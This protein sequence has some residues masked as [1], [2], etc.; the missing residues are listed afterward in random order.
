VAAASHPLDLEQLLV[1]KA[2]SAALEEL[3]SRPRTLDSEELL[4]AFDDDVIDNLDGPSRRRLSEELAG[5][6]AVVAL[7]IMVEMRL[8]GVLLLA[9]KF[10]EAS[11]TSNELVFLEALCVQVAKA[12]ENTR[13]HAQVQQADRLSTLGSL[14]ASLAHELRNPLTS[15]ST[16]VQM[17]PTRHAD[18]SFREKF[19]R[20]VGTELN[21]LIKLTEQLLSFARPAQGEARPLDILAL[22]D[23]VHQLL[24]YQFSKKGVQLNLELAQGMDA[25][26]VGFDTELSQVFVNL[27]LNALQ[28]TETGGSVTLKV[29]EDGKEV[30]ASV[31]DSGCGMSPEQLKHIFDPFYTTKEGGTGLGLPTCLRVMEQH[32]GSLTVSSSL[33]KGSSF[34]LRLPLKTN[35]E[36]LKAA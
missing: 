3:E 7:P 9:T 19:N 27:L 14:S 29:W 26:V 28:A 25:S 8:E 1:L 30:F 24:R 18:E 34:V 17:L 5:L 33:G 36:S 23:R 21:K 11:Y 15:I 32:R 35:R 31:T 12:L 6:G 22:T 16:F 4:A 13:L 2:G 10:S 20:I